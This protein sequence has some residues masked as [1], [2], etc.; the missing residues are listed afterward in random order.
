VYYLIVLVVSLTHT[1]MVE[2]THKDEKEQIHTLLGDA[3]SHYI[4]GE[5]EY[6]T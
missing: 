2:N 1:S 4:V 6:I 3:M 5:E